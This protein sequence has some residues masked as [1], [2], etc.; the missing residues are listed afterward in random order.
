[1]T[2][3]PVRL[4]QNGYGTPGGATTRRERIVRW[5]L[6]HPELDSPACKGEL[7]FH[8]GRGQRGELQVSCQF[9]PRPEAL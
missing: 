5:V 6:E 2:G 9:V 4:E 3:G 1:M 8:V 7:I